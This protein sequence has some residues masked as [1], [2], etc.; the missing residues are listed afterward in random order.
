MVP[1]MPDRNIQKYAQNDGLP[2][3]A[4]ASGRVLTNAQRERKQKMDRISK[5]LRH[6]RQREHIQRLETRLACLER[7]YANPLSFQD[8][9]FTSY[10]QFP[11]SIPAKD[12]PPT[13]WYRIN[14]L[15]SAFIPPREQSGTNNMNYSRQAN[16]I[17]CSVHALHPSQV[18][19][20]DHLNQ[21]ILIRAILQG[22]HTLE[23]KTNDPIWDIV[24]KMDASIDIRS[25]LMTRLT[26]L[27]GIHQML[28]VGNPPSP[29]GSQI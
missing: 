18:C 11:S 1:Y 21:D 8:S 25:G 2:T 24:K 22:W 19:S 26:M 14:D 29:H 13:Q 12:Q 27:R 4:W 5:Q 17:L 3:K 15:P 7:I 16:E 23:N 6:Q 9:T 10:L 20:D 28:L